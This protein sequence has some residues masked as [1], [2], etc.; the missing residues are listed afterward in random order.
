MSN[1]TN[2]AELSSQLYAA[3]ASPELRPAIARL[4]ALIRCDEA[5]LFA[6]LDIAVRLRRTETSIGALRALLDALGPALLLVD[7]AGRPLFV[8][9]RATQILTRRDGLAIGP[10]GLAAASVRATRSLRA[11]IADAAARA[12]AVHARSRTLRLTLA[13]P[14]MRP[15]WLLSI[16]PVARR[17]RSGGG[18]AG[19]AAISIAE[20]ESHTR[21]DAPSAADYFLLTPREADV[22]AL[23]AA[24][25]SSREAAKVLHIGIGTVRTHLKSLF[26]K[27]GARSQ[28]ALAL[29]LQAFAVRD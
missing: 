24:G 18:T 16:L 29:K 5:I 4:G 2:A 7:E 23:L 26:E 1:Q 10:G 17:D 13:R 14:A 21:I 6:A 20:C 12:H 27:T 25:R 19:W 15:P 22:A 3:A 11:A 8:N 9:R 28:M